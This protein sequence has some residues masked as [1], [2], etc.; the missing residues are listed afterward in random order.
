[1]GEN[2]PQNKKD[3]LGVLLLAGIDSVE[4]NA[5]PQEVASTHWGDEAFDVLSSALEEASGL[6]QDDLSLHQAA[7]DVLCLLEMNAR[8][9]KLTIVLSNLLA[10]PP[11]LEP[12][13]GRCEAG[14]ER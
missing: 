14:K 7:N 4:E 5:L 13:L 11:P 10:G 9:R 2:P 1:M 6:L 3:H 8:L 12:S